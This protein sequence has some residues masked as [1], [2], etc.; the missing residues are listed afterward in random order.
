MN[1]FIAKIA[2][3]GL[4]A[5]DRLVARVAARRGAGFLEYALLAAVGLG[6]FFLIN[7]LFPGV[8]S[9]LFERL[10]DAINGVS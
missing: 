8:I 2:S 6:I 7:R 1:N 10:G 3:W 5:E 4:T 9:R